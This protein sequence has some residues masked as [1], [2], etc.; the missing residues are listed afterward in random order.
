MSPE[1]TVIDAVAFR[2]PGAVMPSVRASG[3]VIAY[4]GDCVASLMHFPKW[5]PSVH[6]EERVKFAT[7]LAL[8]TDDALESSAFLQHAWKKSP[9][10]GRAL[11]CCMEQV[12]DRCCFLIPD[13]VL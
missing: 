10:R 6:L 13:P 11:H 7:D 1:F 2:S 12:S 9:A 4:A 3:A 5:P 8:G